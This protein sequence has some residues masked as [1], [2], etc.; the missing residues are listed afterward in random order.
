MHGPGAGV[1]CGH[2]A[3]HVAAQAAQVWLKRGAERYTVGAKRYTVA[4]RAGWPAGRWPGGRRVYTVYCYES[5]YRQSVCEYA[6]VHDA[7]LHSSV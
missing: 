2:E 6:G 4:G 7:A 5:T 1:R 3:R